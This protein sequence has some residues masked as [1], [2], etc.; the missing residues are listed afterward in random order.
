MV[1]TRVCKDVLEQLACQES[2]ENVARPVL[3]EEEEDAEVMEMLVKMVLQDLL[4]QEEHAA[5]GD[6]VDQLEDQE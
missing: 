6:L 4:E 3:L 2:R 1:V 5:K